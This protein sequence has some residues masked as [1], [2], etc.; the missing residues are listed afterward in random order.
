M[1]GGCE[2]EMLGKLGFHVRELAKTLLYRIRTKI[3]ESAKILLNCSC[4][5]DCLYRMADSSN[6]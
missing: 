1:K 2:L 3:Q 5:A 4:L 6:W